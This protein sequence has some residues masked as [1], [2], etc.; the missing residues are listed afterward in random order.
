MTGARRRL[1]CDATPFPISLQN[2]PHRS[3]SGGG[4]QKGDEGMNERTDYLLKPDVVKD[5][6]GLGPFGLHTKISWAQSL[7]MSWSC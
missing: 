5:C 6:P 2:V 7:F 3:L 1:C 4:G